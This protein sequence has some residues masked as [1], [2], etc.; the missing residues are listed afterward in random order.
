M[1]DRLDLNDPIAVLL[2]VA[3]ALREGGV[4]NAAYGGLALAVYGTPRE[5]KD[6][7]LAVAGADS[8]QCQAALKSIGAPLVRVFDRVRFGGHDITRFTLLEPSGAGLNSADLVEPRSPRFARLALERSV[9][10]HL[11]GEKIRVLRPEDFILF[12]VLSTRERD[13]EDA[14]A[15]L[16]SL[17]AS[18]DQAYLAAQSARLATEIV[19]H[20][21]IGRLERARALTG[22]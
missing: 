10:G 11:R 12:K 6:A 4:E 3:S 13:L 17:A 9:E 22:I 7:D 5:T 2:R 21:L 8:G 1:S 14:A 19:D 20:D 18:L 15:V 16:R